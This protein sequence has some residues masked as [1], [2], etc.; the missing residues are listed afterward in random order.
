MA[1]LGGSH[2]LPALGAGLVVTWF[3]RFPADWVI[4][5]MV[6]QGRLS[7]ADAVSVDYLSQCVP[8]RAGTAVAPAQPL[9]PAPAQLP[10]GTAAGGDQLLHDFGGW[11]P[12]PG[13]PC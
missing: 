2:I 8:D 5:G 3:F 4:G 13:W 1:T 12:P 6:F 10:G 9:A 11:P 7:Q